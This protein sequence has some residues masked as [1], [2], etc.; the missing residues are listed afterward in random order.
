MTYESLTSIFH[1]YCYAIYAKL[2]K[3]RTNFFE[4][5]EVGHDN[6]DMTPQNITISCIEK[7]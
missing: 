1:P 5:K 6:D 7:C 3:I 4:F 2:P